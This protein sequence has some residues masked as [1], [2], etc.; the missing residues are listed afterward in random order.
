M[1]ILNK[2]VSGVLLGALTVSLFTPGTTAE[3]AKKTSLKQTKITVLTG[4]TKKIQIKNKKKKRKYVFSSS[5]K[6]IASVTKNGVVRGKKAGKAVITVKETY[7]VKK[8]KKKK[9]IGKVKVTVKKKTVPDKKTP[10]PVPNLTALPSATPGANP[11]VVSHGPA[12]DVKIEPTFYVS[13]DGDDG[14]DGSSSHPFKTLARAKEAVRG[15]DKSKGDIVVEIADGFYPVEDT[16]VFDSKDSGTE[17]GTVIYRAAK[18]AAPVFSGGKKLEGKWL[19]AE[20]VNW[21]RDGVTAYKVPLERSEKLRAIYVNG[22]RASMTSKSQKPAQALGSYTVAKGQAE[23]AWAPSTT[24]IYTGAVFSASFGL[25]ADTRNPQNIELESGSTWAQ[26]LVCAESLSL[27]EEGDTQVNLQMPYGALAQN[28]GWGTAY[29]PTKSNDVTNVFEW[30][31][32]P[33]EFY[34]DQ[35][36][37][38]LYYIPREGEDINSAE[39]IIPETDTIIDMCGDK[40]TSDYV[41]NITFDG[42]GFAYTDWKLYELEGSHGYASVQ[43][44]IVLTKFANVNQHDD[45]YRSYDVPPA[46]IHINSAKNI[47]FLNG[48][49]RH[50][51]YLGAH[52]END[53][54]DCEVTGN[55]IAHTGGAGIV[56]GHPQHVYEN[57]TEIHHVKANNA[58][59]TEKEKFRDGTES[60]PKNITITNNY[61]YENCYFFPGNSPITSF[62]TY[63]MQVLHNFV[64]KC[65]YSGMSIGWGWCNFDG[66]TGSDSQLP[67][68]PTDTSKNNHVNYN[69]VEEICSLLQDAGGIYT[70]GKQGNDDWTEYSEM[71]FNYINAKRKKQTANG[72][73]MINGFHPDEGSAYIKFDSNVVTNIIR[74]VYELNDWRRKHDMIVT[75]GFSNTDRSETTAPNCT[76]DQ[77]VNEQYIW[78]LKGYETVLYSG[79][80]DDYVYMVG[81]DVIPDTDYE[82]AANVRLAVGQKLPRRGLLQ[83]ED[84]VWL[85]KEGTSSFAESDVM[86]KAAGNEKTMDIPTEPGEYKL[87]IR[88]ADG[89][90]SGASTFTLYVGEASNIANVSEGQNVNVS[91]IRPLVLE[92]SAEHSYTLNG[93]AIENG[94][95]IS[96]AGTWTL[97]AN[98]ETIVFTTSVTEANQILDSDITVGSGE[99]FHFS[100]VLSDGTKTIWLAPSG[101]SAF[102]EKD[103]SMSKAA[104]DSSSMKAPTQPGRYILTIVDSK[105]GILSQSDAFVT[106]E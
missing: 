81:Q 92:L 55:Y 103:P 76:L 54:W 61:L 99:E 27:T 72:S 15:L 68:V 106:V 79:L 69:R 49:I 12:P 91:K 38:M 70:L 53:V 57:D 6:K 56:V 24:K 48:E 22:E 96:T 7:Q 82:L 47:R 94:Y 21:L 34:F 31:E 44:S 51:G 20:D 25:P 62:F 105:G 60:V 32:K 59:G 4:K 88:Y 10:V 2:L 33:G 63:N 36:G 90:V 95:E 43:G 100:S 101:L 93:K 58:A 97:K 35:A 75:N 78:P 23:W 98:G 17:Q 67:G 8:K 80:E 9:V 77:Y 87:Y 30:L 13:A 89:S 50:T 39:V 16:I 18:G 102:D 66:E 84:E 64:Y 28:L 11:P 3:A 1:R 37:S 73:K 71:S 86:T 85:A 52:L 45:I 26:Q 104:G 40:P 83:Q 65:S 46:A 41:E 5:K 74:N 19:K 29:S 42:L 14:G